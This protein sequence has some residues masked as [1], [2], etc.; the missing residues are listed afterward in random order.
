MEKDR[1]KKEDMQRIQEGLKERR[2]EGREG[3]KC[4][5]KDGR[6]EEEIKEG[7][8]RWKNIRMNMKD[9]GKKKE[10]GHGNLEW[11]EGKE[12]GRKG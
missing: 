5:G 10:G 3:G 2:K 4:L 6:N 1:G 9:K 7:K 12:G 8:R 11:T